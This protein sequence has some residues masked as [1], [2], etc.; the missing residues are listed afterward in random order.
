MSKI[1]GLGRSNTP[2]LS[3]QQPSS[4]PASKGAGGRGEALR[5]IIYNIYIIYTDWQTL[6]DNTARRGTDWSSATSPKTSV[7][8]RESKVDIAHKCRNSTSALE[9]KCL[10]MCTRSKILIRPSEIG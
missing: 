2:L 3:V 1:A 10:M 4:L 9:A 5:Y 7:S 6:Q 8:Q